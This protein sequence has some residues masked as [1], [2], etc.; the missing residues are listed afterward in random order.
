MASTSKQMTQ[1]FGKT[2]ATTTTVL[3]D[4]ECQMIPA[5]G[6]FGNK[7][8]GPRTVIVPADPIIWNEETSYEYLTLVTT[9]DFGKGYVSKKDVPSGTPLTDTDYWIPVAEYNAQI[10]QIQTDVDTLKESVET[11]ESE[12]VILVL[13]D[14]WSD[15][16]GRGTHYPAGDERFGGWLNFAQK[17][18][19]IRFVSWAWGGTGFIKG[20]SANHNVYGQ[21]QLAAADD[22]FDN[23]KVKKILVFCGVNDYNDGNTDASAYT[24]LLQQL[25]NYFKVTFPNAIP[26]MAFTASLENKAAQLELW[27]TN[28]IGTLAFNGFVSD[29]DS[30][31]WLCNA[32]SY[33]SDK[34]HPSQNGYGYLANYLLSLLFGMDAKLF[35]D[36]I[37]LTTSNENMQVDA[38][39]V[40]KHDY[41]ETSYIISIINEITAGTTETL[42]PFDTDI[43]M[44]TMNS[45]VLSNYSFGEGKLFVSS[46]NVYFKAVTNFSAGSSAR[47]YF[48]I[49]RLI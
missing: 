26:Y 32:S 14:S 18:T 40:L 4:N 36:R 12:D 21:A 15:I 29:V 9:E 30:P 35:T 19:G 48:K 6:P 28:M 1:K 17:A 27:S 24:P 5:N 13:G 42:P 11:L 44:D 25:A 34:L 43:A 38:T 33:L 16:N 3:S 39:V 20:A 7:T 23:S 22:S 47:G 49:N 2:T 41:I 10:A 37:S 46:Q 8:I 45:Y 31:V